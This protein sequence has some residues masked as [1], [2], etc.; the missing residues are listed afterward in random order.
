LIPNYLPDL[1]KRKSWLPVGEVSR[2][3][4]LNPFMKYVHA[5]HSKI[6]LLS[7]WL[8]VTF[9]S[10]LLVLETSHRMNCIN[11]L[12]LFAS[13]LR[14]PWNFLIELRWSNKYRFSWVSHRHVS[15][16]VH[17]WVVFDLFS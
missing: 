2:S 11:L 4:H 13:F 10:I 17:M 9:V 15:H 14:Q 16:L 12:F 3:G 8:H 1:A 6:A 7:L 5:E